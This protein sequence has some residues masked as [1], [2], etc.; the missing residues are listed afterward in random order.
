MTSFLGNV[1]TRFPS[2]IDAQ[3]AFRARALALIVE[4][5]GDDAAVRLEPGPAKWTCAAARE[6]ACHT[7]TAKHAPSVPL[8]GCDRAGTCL[9]VFALILN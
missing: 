7:L 3:R 1:L 8:H 5:F 2:S 9:C 6:T 4:Q